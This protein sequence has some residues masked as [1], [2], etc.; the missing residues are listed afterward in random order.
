MIL[1]SMSRKSPSFGQVIR[2]IDK[3]A[4]D[5]QPLLRNLTPLQAAD[6]RRLVEEFRKNSDLLPSRKNGNMLYH[7]IL[8]VAV[9]PGKEEEQKIALRETA[10]RYLEL[11]ADGLM[12]FGR[13]HHEPGHIHYHFVLS[14]NGVYRWRR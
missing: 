3:S 7:E 4:V 6:R 8:S 9:V 2:R 14:A 13:M 11:R 5:E 10:Q 1:K 12:A